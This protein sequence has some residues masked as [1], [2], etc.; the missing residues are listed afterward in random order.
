MP[1]DRAQAQNFRPNRSP[2]DHAAQPD[3]LA[4]ARV[5]H[6]PE[7]Q[8][9]RTFAAAERRERTAAEKRR[10]V[11]DDFIDH[12]RLDHRG[13]KHAAGFHQHREH[14]LLAREVSQDVREV[15]AGAD[16]EEEMWLHPRGGL[17]GV[18]VKRTN[19]GAELSLP[20]GVTGM[21]FLLT[22]LLVR[23]AKARGA[24]AEDEEGRILTGSDEEME[25]LGM[26]YRRVFWSM[27]AKTLTEG[28]S[29]LPVGGIIHLVIDPCEG[30][31]GHWDDLERKQLDKMS[32]YETAFVPSLMQVGQGDGAKI[33]S[34]Y[35]HLPTL[36]NNQA[37]WVSLNGEHGDI[38]DG[39]FVPVE[40][41]R[42]ILGGRLESL[43]ENWTFI[44]AIDFTSEPGLAASLKAAA[45]HLSDG[46]GNPRDSEAASSGEEL[47]G[48]DWMFLA[49]SVV[50]CM[51]MVAGADGSVDKKEIAT[52]QNLLGSH[53]SCPLP[54]FARILGIAQASLQH[55]GRELQ[56]ENIPPLVHI[57]LLK[58]VLEKF[59]EAEAAQLRS[60][61][62]AIAQAVAESSGG[63]FGFGSKVSKS[64]QG[65]LDFLKVALA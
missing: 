3:V 30:E 43:G 54:A 62:L 63:L 26:E 57:A 47:T 23:T 38:A 28:I 29:T 12:S 60:G 46:T 51:F 18:T 58:G 48:Q 56:E 15:A 44:P 50:L 16:Q 41:F 10:V 22:G 33:F 11:G 37:E 45:D 25:T 27:I 20:A 14:A 40:R 8:R 64:E 6:L 9:F 17:R 35:H 39:G 36:M 52:I 55:I 1:P 2:L 53:Q 49:K 5:F 31:S 24:V 19:G 59:P 4:E 7:P 61:F 34:N 13:G 32:R 42:E 65:V 21:D